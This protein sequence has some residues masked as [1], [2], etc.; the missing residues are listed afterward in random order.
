MSSP[1]AKFREG[2]I[3]TE[4]QRIIDQLRRAF[5]QDA[6]HG[7]AVR[8]LLADVTADRAAAKP[9]AHSHSIWEIVL[10]MSTWENIVRRRL[11]GEMISDLPAEE[12]WPAVRDPSET[13]WRQTLQDLEQANQALREAIAHVDETHL[14]ETV[15]GKSHS[16][17][18]MLHGLIQHDLYHAGQIAVLKR[19]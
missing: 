4:T 6:W 18:T 12:D 3:M 11:Q 1:H 8:E 9:L 10:H 5:E 15:P 7:P 2:E 13:A 17:Y 14:A 16:V 19:A